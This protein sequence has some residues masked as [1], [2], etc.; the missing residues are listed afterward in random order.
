M[1]GVQDNSMSPALLAT[2]HAA[3]M[4]LAGPHQPLQAFGSPL[5]REGRGG[6]GDNVATCIALEMLSDA[7]I[8]RP[9]C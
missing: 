2:Q 3:L 7:H 4:S 5:L 6:L 8:L 9:I 1:I